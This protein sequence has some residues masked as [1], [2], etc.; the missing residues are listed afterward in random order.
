M[1]AESVAQQRMLFTT[2]PIPSPAKQHRDLPGQT[3]LF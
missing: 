1:L 3:F 2:D